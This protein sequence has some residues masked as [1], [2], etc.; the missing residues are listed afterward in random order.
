MGKISIVKLITSPFLK[1]GD[2]FVGDVYHI[3]LVH[4]DNQLET[5][6][7]TIYEYKTM[8]IENNRMERLANSNNK[9]VK[10]LNVKWKPLEVEKQ[11][12]KLRE[13]LDQTKLIICEDEL[14]KDF[15]ENILEV[16]KTIVSLNKNE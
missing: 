6:Y 12:K 4:I 9:L 1:D 11:N 5:T 2:T 15:L 10:P 7:S 13:E 3:K 16:E 14:V 8:T